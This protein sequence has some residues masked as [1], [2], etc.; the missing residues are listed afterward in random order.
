MESWTDKGL[1]IALRPHGEGGAVVSILTENHGRHAGY[2]HG[3]QSSKK[4]AMLEIG[5][6]VAIDWQARTSDQLG[7]Y[8]LEQIKNWSGAVIDHSHRLSS[9]LSACHLCELALPEREKHTELYHGTCALFEMLPQ[10]IWG[11]AYVMWEI[12]LLG[13]LGFAIDLSTCAA[14]GDSEDLIYISPKTGRAVSREG[15]AA[16]KDKLLPL[17]DFLKKNNHGSNLLGTEEDLLTGLNL[18]G[19]FLEHIVFAQHS[20][21]IPEA[22]LRFHA[23]FAKKVQMNT[24]EINIDE[25]LRDSA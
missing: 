1:I 25:L 24:E 3:A 11:E 6:D 9:L 8:K 20:K 7:T 21:G 5:T 23:Q 16:Y 14:G 12:A 2:V 10:D 13:E 19:Y 22:R 18:T 15:G 17:P 4:R